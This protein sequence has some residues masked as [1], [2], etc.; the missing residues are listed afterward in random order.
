MTELTASVRVTRRGVHGEI[1]VAGRL[2]CAFNVIHAVVVPLVELIIGPKR[3]PALE[4][5]EADSDLC[6]IYHDTFDWEAEDSFAG[7]CVEGHLCVGIKSF[8]KPWRNRRPG[9]LLILDIGQA[10]V[11]H[12]PVKVAGKDDPVVGLETERV[13]DG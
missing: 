1:V 3:E 4:T 2:S 9:C 7:E 12:E 11:F 13:L 8:E 6:S 10:A 5:S